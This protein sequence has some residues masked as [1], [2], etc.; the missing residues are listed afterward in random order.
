MT[1]VKDVEEQF[2]ELS[3]C[4]LHNPQW[5]PADVRSVL[6]AVRSDGGW[7]EHWEDGSEFGPEAHVIIAVELDRGQYG[8]LVASEDYTGHGC[9]CGSFTGRYETFKDLV[10]NGLLPEL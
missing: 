7:N 8:L 2:Q 1:T 9:Q 6:F 5:T 4:C 3:R 10:K